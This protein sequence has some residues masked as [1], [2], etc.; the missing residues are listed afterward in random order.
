MPEAGGRQRF[1]VL[2]VCTGNICRSPVIERLLEARFAEVGVIAQVRSAGTA[3]MLGAG[4]PD[5]A[6]DLLERYDGS[7]RDHSPRQL[8]AADLRRADLVLTATRSH[9]AAVAALAPER[10]YRAFV[11]AEF[12]RLAETALDDDRFV[13]AVADPTALAEVIATYRDAEPELPPAVEDLPDPFHR[14]QGVWDD[15]GRRIDGATRRLA[16]ALAELAPVR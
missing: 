15:V 5:E 3:A 12:A 9:R 13:G 11:L 6:F 2:A 16:E 10:A 14:A 1:E 7:T 4:M 8:T